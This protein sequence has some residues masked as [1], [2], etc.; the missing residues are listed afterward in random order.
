MNAQG[1]AERP[2]RWSGRHKVWFEEPDLVGIR[3][4]GA[5]SGAELRQIIDWRVDFGAGKQVFYVLCDLTELGDVSPAALRVMNEGKVNEGVRVFS[6][7]YGARFT[8]RVLVDMVT[9]S[10]KALHPDIL[11]AEGEVV[12]VASEADARALIGKRRSAW[13]PH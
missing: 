12:F 2:L 6:V 8:V 7:C 1:S 3:F 13:K 11:E 4:S 10:L 9:R 5:V